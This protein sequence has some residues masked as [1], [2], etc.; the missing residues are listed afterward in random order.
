[1]VRG[2]LEPDWDLMGTPF[3]VTSQGKE[4]GIHF[5][6]AL[7]VCQALCWGIWTLF[8]FNPVW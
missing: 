3:K 1:M 2:E 5:F 8:C 7:T 6:R 4:L